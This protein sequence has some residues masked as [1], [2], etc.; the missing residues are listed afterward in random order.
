MYDSNASQ[1]GK[2]E[3]IDSG[4]GTSILYIAACTLNTQIFTS[5]H[6]NIFIRFDDC[7]VMCARQLHKNYII[8]ITI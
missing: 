4:Q 3:G 6:N 7:I 1:M 5:E 8:L 2:K